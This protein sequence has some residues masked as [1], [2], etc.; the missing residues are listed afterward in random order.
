MR[1]RIAST[2][3]CGL[4]AIRSPQFGQYDSTS[5]RAT[6]C[7][8]RTTGLGG[9]FFNFS[10]EYGDS[11][12]EAA[13]QTTQQIST[14]LKSAFGTHDW[15]HMRRNTAASDVQWIPCSPSDTCVAHLR[16]PSHLPSKVPTTAVCPSRLS[17]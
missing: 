3:A 16:G 6:G 12:R 1:S 5:L 15:N 11:S 10:D 2:F 7:A 4:A 13:G 14:C 9:F 17:Q 8:L